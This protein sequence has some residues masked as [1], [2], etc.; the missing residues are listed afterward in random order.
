MIGQKKKK[1]FKNLDYLYTKNKYKN[2]S[3]MEELSITKKA[4]Y[5]LYSSKLDQT[6]DHMPIPLKNI[7]INANIYEQVGELEIIQEYENSTTKNLEVAY[8]F[9]KTLESVFTRLTVYIDNVLIKTVIMK[10]EKAKNAYNE[11]IKNNHTAVLSTVTSPDNTRDS[12]MKI[13][14]GNFPPEKKLLAKFT[15]ATD[16]PIS[17]NKYYRFCLPVEMRNLHPGSDQSVLKFCEWKKRQNY[18][19][20]LQNSLKSELGRQINPVS[21]NDCNEISQL[22][23]NC[24]EGLENLV[25]YEEKL[26]QEAEIIGEKID[27]TNPEAYT[28]SLNINIK[29][30]SNIKQVLSPTHKIVSEISQNKANIQLD[31]TTD[32]N[33]FPN[34]D[35]VLYFQTEY[36]NKPTFLIGNAVDTDLYKNTPKAFALNVNPFETDSENFKSIISDEQ[37]EKFLQSDKLE[38]ALE[39]VKNLE[40]NNSEKNC[41]IRKN[42]YIFVLDRSGSMST[43]K[44]IEMAKQALIFFIQSLPEGSKF[45]IVSYGNDYELMFELGSVDFVDENISKCYQQLEDFSADMGGTNILEPLEYILNTEKFK[46]LNRNIFLITDGCVYNSH[47][48][49]KMIE[50]NLGNSRIFT[51]GI[52]SGTDRNLIEKVAK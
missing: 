41:E 13:I 19:K 35:F 20:N 51:L 29:S 22:L 30:L 7:S 12:S 42:E 39:Y 8:Y 37:L 11:A 6:Q 27:K 1:N 40:A 21:D 16:V 34:T 46:G 47:Q 25:N 43:G 10:R 4:F 9:P 23:G 17:M 38:D 24:F 44:R 18:L 26:D 50:E 28:W 36:T 31:Y 49:Y 2:K 33:K 14:I 45:N 15:V 48:M 32:D 3:K 5:G 52:G